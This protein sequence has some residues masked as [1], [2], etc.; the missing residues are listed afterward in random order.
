MY[1][2]RKCPY[3]KGKAVIR[4]ATTQEFWDTCIHCGGTGVQ[5]WDEKNKEWING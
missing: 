4:P 3:C 1:K 2:P 5:L